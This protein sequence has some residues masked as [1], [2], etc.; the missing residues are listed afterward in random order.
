MWRCGVGSGLQRCGSGI[1]IPDPGTES[2]SSRIRI[3]PHQSILTQKIVS[4]LSEICSRVFIP[5]LD[6]DFLPIPDPGVKN[7]KAPD[8]GSAT[9]QGWCNLTK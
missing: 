4:K 3:H 6:L 2:F 8:P 7:K 9:L 1:F 5:D